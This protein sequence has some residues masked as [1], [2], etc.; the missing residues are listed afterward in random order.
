MAKKQPR[1]SVSMKRLTAQRL[2]KLAKMLRS[3]GLVDFET[4]P[5]YSP[6]IE[7]LVAKLSEDRG[8]PEQVAVEAFPK[9]NTGRKPK[10]EPEPEDY[11]GF[12]F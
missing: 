11:R 10:H 2:R 7:Y 6:T 5:G 12:T 8:I 9:M 3:E 4:G 1:V